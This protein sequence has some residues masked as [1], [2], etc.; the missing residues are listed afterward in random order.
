MNIKRKYYHVASIVLVAMLIVNTLSTRSSAAE[1][2]T[3]GSFET[4]T[5][6][7][8]TAVNAA[9]SWFNWQTVTAGFT[10]GFNN[11]ASPQAGLRDAFQGVAANAGGTY[12]LTQDITIPAASTASMTWRHRYQLDNA[13]FCTGTA[14]GT[15]NFSVQIMN[16]SNVLLQ[17]LYS[18]NVAAETVVDTGWHSGIALLNS[19]AGQTIRIRFVSSVTATLAGPGSLEID[20][21]S[22]QAPAIPTSA[23]ATVS[24]RASTSTGVG[25]PRSTIT[26]TDQYGVTRRAMT[27][28][29][30]NY[31]FGD[32]PVGETYVINIANKQYAFGEPTR[33]I[34]VSDNIANLDFQ[35]LF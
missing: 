12:S 2:I 26:L 20:A 33:V 13:T 16:T 31:T 25:I 23:N 15:S 29:F 27:N 19:Y 35:A 10:T 7:G 24:G 30:G 3:N 18:R 22:V 17:T 34:T 6:A 32:V 11:P 1:L 14:C 8:W 28:G 9:G 5:F 4:G 21:V